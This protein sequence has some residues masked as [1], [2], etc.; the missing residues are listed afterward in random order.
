MT[1]W[2]VQSP[3]FRFDIE[4]EEDL[5][6]EVARIHGYDS[7]PEAT[8]I[9][10]TPLAAVTETQVN[11]QAVADSL[12]ARDYQEVITYSFVDAASDEIADGRKIGTCSG[13]SDLDQKC[14]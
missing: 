6:E 13:E 3:G 9:A 12:V 5:I 8:A 10:E 2:V 11:L 7:I 4:I 1:G 14:P